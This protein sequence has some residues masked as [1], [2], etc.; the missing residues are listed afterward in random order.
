MKREQESSDHTSGWLC[1]WVLLFFSGAGRGL[2][3]NAQTSRPELK[4]VVI[5]SRHGVRSPTWSAQRL[6]QYSAEPWPDWGVPPGYLTPHGKILMKLFGAYDREYFAQTGLLS[7]TGCSDADKVL[8]RA[9]SE[10]RTIETARALAE[11]MLPGCLA[12]IHSEPQGKRDPLFSPFEAGIAPADR[13]LAAAAVSGRIGGN[14][15]ALEELYRPQLEKMQQVLLGCLPGSPCPPT[16]SAPKKSLFEVATSL[17]PG[18]GDHLAEL[19]GPLKT[20]STFSE[21]FLLE[22]TEGLKGKELGWGRVNESGVRD[23]MRLHVVYADLMRQT[24]FIART[25]AS[26]LLDHILKTM[27]QAVAGR[28]IHGALGKRDDR[29]VVLVGHDTNISNVAGALGLSWLVEGYQRDDTPPGGALVFEMW[30]QPETGEYTVRMYYMCQTL[31]QMRRAMPLTPYSAPARAPIFLPGC[32]TAADGLS[33]VWESFRSTV[34]ASVD[35]KY[36][37]P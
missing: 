26:N 11:G 8:F 35:P 25:R 29:A 18:K 22:Y 3:Q 4:F 1:L 10:E 34:E 24:P 30:R 15:A 12:E 32:S 21:D 27:Q 37:K 17:S 14:P 19:S 23:M 36:I 7:S 5:L 33:C 2:A 28:P 9:D 13:G 16:G 31:E 20:A 6:N